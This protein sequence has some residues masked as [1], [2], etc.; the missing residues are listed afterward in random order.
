MGYPEKKKDVGETKVIDLTEGSALDILMRTASSKPPREDFLCVFN[1][2]NGS[3]ETGIWEWKWGERGSFELGGA[4]Q[5]SKSKLKFG[6]LKATEVFFHTNVPSFDSPEGKLMGPPPIR[7]LGPDPACSFSPSLL[8]SCLQKAVRRGMTNEAVKLAAEL[9]CRGAVDALR[10]VL[11]IVLED[12]ILHPAYPLLCFWMM[13]EGGGY[14]LGPLHASGY[15]NFVRDITN[16]KYREVFSSSP[17]L[18]SIDPEEGE[19][20][21]PP[22]GQAPRLEKRTGT[23]RITR[24][25]LHSLGMGPSC[26]VKAIFA[27]ALY[28]GMT[29]DVE[30]LK[31]AAYT[32]ALRFA[33]DAAE[34]STENQARGGGSASLWAE[35]GFWEGLKQ[36]RLREASTRKLGSP[37]SSP[38]IPPSSSWTRLLSYAHGTRLASHAMLG[39]FSIQLLLTPRLTLQDVPLSG[40]DFHVSE[41]IEDVLREGG[42]FSQSTNALSPSPL[43]LAASEAVKLLKEEGYHISDVPGILRSAMWHLRSAVNAREVIGAG[44]DQDDDAALSLGTRAAFSLLLPHFDN[45]SRAHLASRLHHG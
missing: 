28:G 8:K 26:L 33:A 3:H 23:A 13:C 40:V 18:E 36:H 29:G 37:L 17:L 10:R 35:N 32:W 19:T 43:R 22:W 27:R 15:L 44:E 24:A 5:V 25:A 14:K 6:G 45:F 34:R 31:R 42:V 1:L 38:P 39:P 4:P 9:W 16:C 11:V 7:T 30:L 41:V 21:S 20:G 12:T 2:G